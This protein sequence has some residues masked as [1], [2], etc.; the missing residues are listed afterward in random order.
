MSDES[1]DWLPGLLHFESFDGDWERYIDAVYAVFRRDF[2]SSRPAFD[3]RPLNLKRH[4]I[5]E[6][7]EATFWH[8]ISEGQNEAERVPDLRRC[9][10]IAW[11]RP[12]IEA[13]T[14]GRVLCWPNT[15][16]REQRFVLA[17]EDF[18]YV[19]ILA[20]RGHFLLPWTAYCV[21]RDHQRRK[22]QK[23]WEAWKAIKG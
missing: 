7:R 4:P 3:G 6:G 10:R 8:F 22:L 20:D 16:G 12:I 1:L 17:V 2:V 15:R 21:E 11:P 23:E 5:S 9:E 13:V 18:S 19:V 14:S